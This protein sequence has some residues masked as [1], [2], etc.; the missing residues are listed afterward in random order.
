M[1][2]VDRNQKIK[3]ISDLEAFTTARYCRIEEGQVYSSG[4]QEVRLHLSGLVGRRTVENREYKVN[5][6]PLPLG[7]YEVYNV[8]RVFSGPI[9]GG[10]AKKYGV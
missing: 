4:R 1:F 7:G 8:E 9:N 2:F 5:L 10:N 6:Q 3:E